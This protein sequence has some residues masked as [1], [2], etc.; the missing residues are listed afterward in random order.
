MLTVVPPVLLLLPLDDDDVSHGFG[1]SGADVGWKLCSGML[2][3]DVPGGNWLGED[4][5]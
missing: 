5:Q 1:V 3:A 2:L 4:H